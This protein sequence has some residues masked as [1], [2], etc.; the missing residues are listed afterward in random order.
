MARHYFL[1]NGSE[2]ENNKYSWGTYRGKS[3]L[4]R[5]KVRKKVAGNACLSRD[6]DANSDGHVLKFMS[7]C[8]KVMLHV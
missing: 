7:T 3:E 1:V 8:I 2:L 5:T 6:R 4:S